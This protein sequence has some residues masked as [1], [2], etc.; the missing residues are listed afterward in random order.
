[1]FSSRT[2]QYVLKYF[3]LINTDAD[4]ALFRRGLTD[5]P[6]EWPVPL[7]P[8]PWVYYIMWPSIYIWNLLWMCYGLS[9]I[10]R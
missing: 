4:G 3:P 5:E 6:D 7:S 1:M 9:T 2:P 10:L 8:P